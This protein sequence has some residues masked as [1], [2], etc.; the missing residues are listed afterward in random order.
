MNPF[1]DI[2]KSSVGFIPKTEIQEDQNYRLLL[3]KLSDLMCQNA[4][5]DKSTWSYDF[6]TLKLIALLR[7]GSI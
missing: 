7:P 2:R 6:V 3:Q 1:T 5:K 4:R